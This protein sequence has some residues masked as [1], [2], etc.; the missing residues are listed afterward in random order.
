MPSEYICVGPAYCRAGLQTAVQ[1]PSPEVQR[2][3]LDCGR[4]RAGSGYGTRSSI[5]VGKRGH[6]T[7]SSAT[8]GV[9]V[10]QPVLHSSQEGWG[11]ASNNR[12]QALESFSEEIQVQD[13]H[14]SSHRESDPVRGLVRHDRSKDAYFHISILPCHRKFLRFAFGGEAYQYRVL[15]FGLALSPR[16]FTKCMDAAL[17]PLRLQGI[18]VLNY[19]DDWLI[20]AK[21][22]D[23]AVRHRDVVLAHIRCLGLR[24]NTKK[25]VSTP[26]Q[27]TMF[28]GVVWDSTTMR[29]QM[30]PAR[31]G[32][33]QAMVSRVKLGH[34]LTVKQF[35]VL[36][37]HMAAAS[38]VIPSGLLHMRPLQWWLRAKGFS[39][40]GNPF[41]MI[42]VMR[43]CLV[44]SSY[45]GNLGSCPR[46]QCWEHH[47]AGK[48]FQQM[49]PSLVGA[50]S[51][52]AALREVCG[53]PGILPGTSTAWKCWRSTKL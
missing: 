9:R 29:A 16:T 1:L 21:S 7:C 24:L 2:G 19:I 51:W 43:R 17:A 50:R 44:P 18:R 46:D 10:L 38:S 8:Q 27:R 35:Q 42:R 33:I 26:S 39:L 52:T 49:P 22:Y 6:R 36:L 40:R 23:M 3:G 4:P 53:R 20:L 31:V 13:A 34:N 48:P 11:V 5:P 28:L 30:S 12:S 45:G 14:N 37:G 32:S 41:R 25:S 47:V 15:P